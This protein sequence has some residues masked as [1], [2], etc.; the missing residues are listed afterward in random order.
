V[1]IEKKDLGKGQL[2]ITVK[3]DKA[4]IAKEMQAAADRLSTHRPIKGFRPGKAP[5]DMVKREFGEDKILSEAMDD[6][7][8]H[9][10]N[11]ILE[12]EQLHI[13]GQ[14]GFA[15]LPLASTNEAVAYKATITLMPKVKI[16]NWQTKQIKSKEISVPDEELNK[17][18]D[19][20]LGMSTTE[21]PKERASET[22][23]KVSIDL[24][25]FVDGKLI[26]GGSAKD[27]PVI[28][29]EKRMIPGFEENLVGLK[30]EDEKKF[31]L[32]FP[33]KYEAKH[34]AGKM[35]EFK[36]KVKQ[37]LARIKPEL[38]DEFAKK[39]GMQTLQELKDRIR[40]NMKTDFIEREEERVEI[41]AIKQIN[42]ASEFDPIAPAMVSDMVADLVH[43]F[44]HTL[45]HKGME[46]DAYLKSTNKTLDEIKKEFEPKAIERI[47]TSLALAQL[48]V[49]EKIAVTP[50]ELSKEIEHSKEKD[51][52]DFR[53]HTANMILNKKL[54]DFIKGK[55]I[56]K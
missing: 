44:E 52:I 37:V 31:S 1:N 21:E 11:E 27:F 9:S 32:A 42:D 8:E 55:I 34:L 38:N 33:E 20:L 35:A 47:K 25:V 46:L 45:K 24:E 26:D 19:Q 48:A 15:P 13:Y 53:R 6:I 3:L 7:V 18:L 16:G 50:E 30:A 41:E 5:L 10:L 39:V 2:E 36:I 40:E 43:D 14:I 54:I 29:G 56:I 51:N 49:D 28:L 17:A 4:D 22:N 12:K 23:D